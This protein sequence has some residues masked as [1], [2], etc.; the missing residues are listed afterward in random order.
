MG[1]CRERLG[2]SGHEFRD[3]VTI[4]TACREQLLEQGFLEQYWDLH[5]KRNS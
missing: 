4:E 1:T 5:S 2:R 3:K